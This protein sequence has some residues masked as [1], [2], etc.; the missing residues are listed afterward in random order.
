MY[1]FVGN[2][3]NFMF[4]WV[5]GGGEKRRLNAVLLLAERRLAATQ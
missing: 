1:Y 5:W 2:G 4:L 3:G